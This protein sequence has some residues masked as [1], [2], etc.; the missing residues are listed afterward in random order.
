MAAQ[1]ELFIDIDRGPERSR[2]RPVG[3]PANLPASNPLWPAAPA[4]AE[5]PDPGEVGSAP[6]GAVPVEPPHFPPD[7]RPDPLPAGDQG[8][9]RPLATDLATSLA[10][11]RPGPSITRPVSLADAL[12]PMVAAPQTTRRLEPDP[13]EL[14][15]WQSSN[16]A[17]HSSVPAQESPL[18]VAAGNQEGGDA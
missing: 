13:E 2:T 6:L 18:F 14:S 10:A 15:D 5:R 16:S 11:L 4:P 7:T 12:A 1:H 8:A 9:A 17:R 3:A